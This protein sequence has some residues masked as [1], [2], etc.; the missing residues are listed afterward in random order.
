MLLSRHRQRLTAMSLIEVMIA[1]A[2]FAAGAAAILTA[3][4]SYMNV[5]EHERKLSAAWRVL[6]AEGSLVRTLADDQ[7]EWTAP[8]TLG[9]DELGLPSATPTFTVTRTPVAD[10]PHKGARQITLVAAWTERA[11]PRKATLVIHR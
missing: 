10:V 1:G 6:Q 9:V 7:A 5:V 8:S 11:G 4:A 2:V 3:T